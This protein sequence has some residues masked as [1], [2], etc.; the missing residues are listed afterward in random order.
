[1]IGRHERLRV[2]L[3]AGTLGQGGAE[4]QLV[5]MAQALRRAD[6]EVRVYCLMRGE[7]Y[8]PALQAM[9]IQPIW[10]GRH[11]HP[12]MRLAALIVA[13]RQYRPH[14]LQSAH[15]YTNLYTT[16]SGRVWH[17]IALG[18]IRN[19]TL[20]DINLNGRWGQSL[21]R[22]PS[23]LIANSYTGKHNAES[24]GI[25]PD[26]I[27]VVTNVI[28]LAAFDKLAAQSVSQTTQLDR[29]VAVAI[30]TLKAQKRLDRFLD[31]LALARREIHHLKGV[32]IG[33]GSERP[34]LETLAR[35]LSL[36]PDGLLFLG[37]R[38]DVPALLCQ[39]NMH[40]LSSDHEGFPN[41]LL[42]AMAA[43]LPAITTPAG[44]A[45][46][47]VQDGLTGYVLDFEDI[48]GMAERMI[49]LAKSSDL[50]H[51]L[52]EAGRQRVEQL[53]GFEGLA[54][55]LLSTYRSIAERHGN[56]RLLNVLSS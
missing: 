39:A 40:V 10:I 2:A 50:Q 4:K 53:Y 42:E 54:E 56:H 35:N 43:R 17:A 20:Q 11:A 18:A 48:D 36:L 51:K 46:V 6:V 37:R 26:R 8:E 12:L 7:F 29:P 3:V 44:D 52:G 25:K 9:G 34:R 23:A 47:V 49:R 22:V 14:V 32:L 21:L 38:S 45:G 33:D 1:M 31:A 24:L 19:D 41:V 55:R 13:L 30:A 27:H 28:D 15:F 5:Y 16:I